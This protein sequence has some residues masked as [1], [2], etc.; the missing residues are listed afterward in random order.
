MLPLPIYVTCTTPFPPHFGDRMAVTY[1]TTRI[2]TNMHVDFKEFDHSYPEA[3]QL[4][5]GITQNTG[6]CFKPRYLRRLDECGLRQY[7][8]PGSARDRRLKTMKLAPWMLR[9]PFFV[10]GLVRRL[11]QYRHPIMNE[12]SARQI[13][14]RRGDTRR[15]AMPETS[16]QSIAPRTVA[17]HFLLGH[18]LGASAIAT[19]SCLRRG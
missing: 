13:S 12:L 14:L 6:Q 9:E 19:L 15:D 7:I 10:P 2:F 1:K 8:K 5:I 18:L 4:G 3:Y 17:R 16:Q 11:Q